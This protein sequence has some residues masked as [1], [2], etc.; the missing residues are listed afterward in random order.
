[1]KLFG[2]FSYEFERHKQLDVGLRV[3]VLVGQLLQANRGIES[4]LGLLQFRLLVIVQRSHAPC[5][6]VG[7]AE[8][9]HRP[10][11]LLGGCISRLR[12]EDAQRDQLFL[13]LEI[14]K[15]PDKFR[16][17][18]LGPCGGLRSQNNGG[19]EAEETECSH[20]EDPP[21]DLNLFT[22]IGSSQAGGSGPRGRLAANHCM[23]SGTASKVAVRGTGPN[24][25]MRASPALRA[26]TL[27]MPRLLQ[28][29]KGGSKS[30]LPQ[31]H[32]IAA[33][34]PRRADRALGRVIFRMP[35]FAGGNHGAS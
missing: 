26:R 34:I 7:L 1:M 3:W 11:K 13:H 19:C 20:N 24:R 21:A 8:P 31:A 2:Q 5:R 4:V 35:T 14:L 15:L 32:Q 33:T 18:L 30:L 16:A 9:V 27:H 28:R 12:V 22:P 29:G 23:K 6:F 10:A 25:S 17:H